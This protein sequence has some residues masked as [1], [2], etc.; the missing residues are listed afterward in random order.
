MSEAHPIWRPYC[1][2]APPPGEWLWH[3][4][5]DPILIASLLALLGL[6]LHRSPA[7]WR[8]QLAAA[9][10][11]V[12]LFIS[13]LCALGSALFALRTLHHLA[14]GLVLAPLLMRAAAELAAHRPPSLGIATILQAA[15]FWAWHAPPL[16]SEALSNDVVFWLMQLSLI[17]SATI[18]WLALRH[19]SSLAAAASV[20]ATMVQ[21][22]LLGALL[23]FGG[24]PFYAP[25][26]LTT[27]EWGLSPLADQQTA[28]L[29]M[30]VL[31]SGAYLALAISMLYRALS[32]PALPRRT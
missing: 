21:M 26:W 12:V 10:V 4:N 5:P 13:P 18:W 20:L 28:G 15:V 23:V 29:I 22:G 17:G 27:G 2:A 16:Y 24:R 19:A 1:G 6:G 3:W 11:A 25:H 32:F 8:D 7:T 30:W 31:G 9:L 14:L